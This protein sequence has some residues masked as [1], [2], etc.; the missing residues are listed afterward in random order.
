MA[1]LWKELSLV[2]D[3]LTPLTTS[4]SKGQSA[5]ASDE[6]VPKASKLSHDQWK[7]QT[8]GQGILLVTEHNAEVNAHTSVISEERWRDLLQVLDQSAGAN[9]LQ[10][11]FCITA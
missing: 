1:D 10:R 9:L 11:F 7:H 6:S 8:I 2:R 5:S 3:G 4:S